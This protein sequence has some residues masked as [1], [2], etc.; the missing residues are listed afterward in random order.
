MMEF[1]FVDLVKK[2]HKYFG[3]YNYY[4]YLCRIINKSMSEEIKFIYFLDGEQVERENINWETNI[5][6]IVVDE[7][8]N[9]TTQ[10]EKTKV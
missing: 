10:K 5:T 7:R 8:V 2:L 3:S 1:L 4:L 9:I 6:V